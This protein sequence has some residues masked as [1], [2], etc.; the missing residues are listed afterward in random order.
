MEWEKESFK[1]KETQNLSVKDIPP[2]LVKDLASRLCARFG[3]I[4]QTSY[5]M[6]SYRAREVSLDATRDGPFALLAKENDIMWG[7]GMPDDCT[8]IVLVV[9]SPEAQ[10]ESSEDID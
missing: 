6:H 1:G 4:L 8:I 2:S 7:G 10:P 9:T 3:V 5:R